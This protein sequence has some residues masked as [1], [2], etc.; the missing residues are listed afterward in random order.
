VS[1]GFVHRGPGPVSTNAVHRS[2]RAGQNN[3]T[4]VNQIKMLTKKQ[5]KNGQNA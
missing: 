5:S 4:P 1:V 2:S 3:R